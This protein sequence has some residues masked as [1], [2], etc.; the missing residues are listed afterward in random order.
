MRERRDLFTSV[1]AAILRVAFL[2]EAVL[3]INS[4]LAL[5]PLAQPKPVSRGDEMKSAASRAAKLGAV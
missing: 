1:R 3:A 5:N 4:S 2:A